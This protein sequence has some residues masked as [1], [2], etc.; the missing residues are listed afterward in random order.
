LLAGLVASPA[1]AQTLEVVPFPLTVEPSSM[2]AGTLEYRAVPG[3]FANLQGHGRLLMSQVELPGHAPVTLSLEPMSFDLQS[4][5]MQVNGQ[6]TPY[7]PGD[8]SLWKGMVVGDDSSEVSL[9][10]SSYGCNGW[11]KADGEFYHVLSFPDVGNDW[12]H[13]KARIVP[14]D[15]MRSLG[16]PALPQCQIDALGGPTQSQHM[17][18]MASVARNPQ[19]FQLG[20]TLECKVAVETDYQYYQNWNNLTATQNYTLTLLGAISDRYLSQINVVL[21]YPY[22]QFYTSSND[23]WTSQGGGS[24]AL[25]NEFRTAWAGNIPSGANLAHFLSGANLGG[26]VAY[27]DALCNQSYGFGVS[28]NVDGGTQFPISQSSN[29]WDFVVAAHEMGHNFGTSHTHNY[30][31]P[32]DQC[33]PNGY[34]G[35]CQTSQVCTNQGTVMSYCHLCSGGMNNITTFFHPQVVT[36]MRAGA[37]SSC[38]Q[39]YSGGCTTDAFEPNDSCGA[40][41]AVGAGTYNNLHACSSNSDYYSINLAP[42]EQLTVNLTFTHSQGNINARLSDNTCITTLATGTSNTNNETLVWTNTSGSTTE[43]VLEVYISGGAVTNAYSMSLGLVNT[44]P[45]VGQVDDALEN[46]DSCG[47]AVPMTDGFVGGLFVSKTDSDFYQLCVPSGG[48]LQADIFFT[49]ATADVD[50][51]LYDPSACGGGTGTGLAEGYSA[52]NDETIVWTNTSATNQTVVLEVSVYPSSAGNCNTYDMAL[53]GADGQCLGGNSLGSLFCSP[54]NFNSRGLTG[55]VQATGTAL[56]FVNDLTLTATD[57]PINQFGYFLCSQSQGF[58]ANPGGSMGDLC[59]AVNI[60]R[61]SAQVASSGIFGEIQTAIDL[62]DMPTNP[63]EAVMAG[64]TWNFQLWYR[65]FILTSTSNFTEGIEIQ[66]Q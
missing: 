65:D 52:T 59:L 48:T 53:V 22:L 30:C 66:F 47:S 57:L 58:T 51:F 54:A 60:G 8:L 37:D 4:V 17:L 18:D 39:P 61:F 7:D 64:Q 42:S 14:D 63:H 27:L 43:V 32:I 9:G 41:V 36:V 33:A 11:I 21:T 50:M 29:T 28:G 26:G 1:P 12:A 16:A 31:P 24:S 34:F 23:P 19:V 13:A 62:T 25:L 20:V 40:A 56:V 10:F 35:S 38:L 49:H 46:N 2:V 55:R 15:V 5:G 3:A 6:P 44:D 45:C